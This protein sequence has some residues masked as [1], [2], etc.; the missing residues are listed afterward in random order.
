MTWINEEDDRTYEVIFNEK[1]GTYLIWY[2]DRELPPGNQKI[3]FTGTR[4]E[5]ID[6]MGKLYKEKR[7]SN[8]RKKM[9]EM[10]KEAQEKKK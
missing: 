8:L 6:K 2:A 9:D 5:C 1:E 10:V 3:G 4:Q 7:P